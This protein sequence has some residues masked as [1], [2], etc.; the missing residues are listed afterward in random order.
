MFIKFIGDKELV[1]ETD[2]YMIEKNDEFV[3]IIVNSV[4]KDTD[5]IF[6][7]PTEFIVSNGN[8]NYNSA[9]VMNNKGE[10]I[11]RIRI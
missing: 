7:N 9:F 6:T 11:D 10:T 3:R 2:S 4:R 1:I 8:K 5:L